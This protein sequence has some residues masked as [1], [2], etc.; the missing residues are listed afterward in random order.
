[1]GNQPH[2]LFYLIPDCMVLSSTVGFSV[3]STVVPP[4]KQTH[5]KVRKMKHY[6]EY[7]VQ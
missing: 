4:E 6:R 5:T 2:F 7:A 1:M 3:V